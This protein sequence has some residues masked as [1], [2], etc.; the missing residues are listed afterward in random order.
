MAERTI[1]QHLQHRGLHRAAL[2]Q[3][4]RAFGRFEASR[5]N[6]LWVG[7]VLIGPYVPHP[8]VPT[9]RRAFLFLLVDDFRD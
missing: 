6:E 5:P 2:A 7:D 4:P 8:R 9:S 3:Q 1:R